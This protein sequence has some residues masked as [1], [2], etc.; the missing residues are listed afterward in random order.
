MKD[1]SNSTPRLS[2]TVGFLT[3]AGLAA[4]VWL[5]AHKTAEAYDTVSADE[6]L[7]KCDEAAAALDRR[8]NQLHIA[9]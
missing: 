2:W 4:A 3:G 8:L 1:C 5:M 7:K 6:L 9:C